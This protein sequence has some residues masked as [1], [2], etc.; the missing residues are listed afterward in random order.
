MLA[1]FIVLLA[2]PP[3]PVKAQDTGTPTFRTG[4]A[5]VHV[6][7][8]VT[9]GSAV[10][11]TLT[12]QD[13]AVTDEGRPQ[14]IVYFGHYSEPL[15]L[16]LL[17]DVSG[18]M[19]KWIERISSTAQHALNY[20]RPG[21]RVAILVFGKS[22]EVHQEFSDN[23][24]ETARQI[25]SAVQAHDVG[26]GT[27][28]NHSIEEAARYMQAKARPQGRRAILVL[29]DNLS[30]GQT[31]DGTVLEELYRADTVLN[32]IVVGSAE[33]PDPARAN[34]PVN[35]DGVAADVFR[36]AEETGGEAVRAD[37]PELSFPEMIDRMRTRYSLA[38]HAPG[39]DPG[40]FRH[41]EVRLAGQGY[42]EFPW[43]KVHA[44]RGY[45]VAQ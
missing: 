9:I 44:R 8:Q 12:Q 7:A 21:D 28:I 3:A 13:F 19:Q 11:T 45:F 42:R 32:A 15:S 37:N 17:L 43:A 25:A 33:R 14:Q 24:A 29:T 2:S 4:V 22:M 27:A 41:I 30:L 34:V 26:A 5:D 36:L 16:I 38:Y 20:L 40:S 39:G 1:I 35:Q 18:S 10:I 23:L 6:D 31:R